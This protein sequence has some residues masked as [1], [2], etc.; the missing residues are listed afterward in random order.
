M[1]GANELKRHR[2]S[3]ANGIKVTASRTETAFTAERNNFK[4]TT[5]FTAINGMTVIIIAAMK[6]F[7]DIFQNGI[8]DIDTAACN[9]IKMIVKNS[10]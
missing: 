7:V 6:H 3:P 2:S 4:G 1:S 10:L 8:T 5:K 9:S